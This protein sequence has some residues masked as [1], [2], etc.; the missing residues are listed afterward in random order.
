MIR[1][2]IS[3]KII[4]RNLTGDLLHYFWQVAEI[5]QRATKVEKNEGN[6][7]AQLTELQRSLQEEATKSQALTIRV[8]QMETDRDTLQVRN[9]ENN[10]FNPQ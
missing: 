9:A 1:R 7:T 3:E 8:R 6:L 10:S 5:D 4:L 2:N